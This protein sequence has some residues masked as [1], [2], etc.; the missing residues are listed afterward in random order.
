MDDPGAFAVLAQFI[1]ERLIT[2]DRDTLGISHEALLT[3]WPR[4]HDWVGADRSGLRNLR[5]LRAQAVIAL[6]GIC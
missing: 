4:L 5:N 3:A 2:A 6:R 1:D